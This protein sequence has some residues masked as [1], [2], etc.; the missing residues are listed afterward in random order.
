MQCPKCHARIDTAHAD[1]LPGFDHPAVLGLRR[2]TSAIGLFDYL[3]IVSQDCPY[4]GVKLYVID[5]WRHVR[6]IACVAL[7]RFLCYPWFPSPE[8]CGTTEAELWVALCFAW[9]VA[10]GT[11]ALWL[12]S[13][14]TKLLPLHFDLIP[15]D[16][17]LRL[18]L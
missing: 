14:S 10:L 11:L 13:V 1:P 18:D 7:A 8:F 3:A 16:G 9:L 6:G 15:Q 5:N 4:C 12:L 2:M 17:P